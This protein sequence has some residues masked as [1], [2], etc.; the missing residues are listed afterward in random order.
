MTSRLEGKVALVTGAGSGIGR[1]CALMFAREGAQVI[2]CDRDQAGTTETLS[3]AS[4]DKLTIDMRSPV[5]LLD[6]GEVSRLITDVARKYT[7]IDILLT[8]AGR[9]E[10]AP[11]PD[12]TM[13]QWRTTM[14]GELDIVFL[15]VRAAWP[16]MVK[17]GGGSIINFASAAA[18]GGVKG[19]P[20]LAHAAGKGGVL[21]MT[22][23]LAVEGAPHRIRANTIAPGPIATAALERAMNK[24]PDFA[25][26][27]RSKVLLDRLG[28]P[29]DIAYAAVFLASNESNWVTG[30][31]FSVDGGMTAW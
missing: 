9:A 7:R 15:P 26:A 3:M 10:F 25:A 22:R 23:Q 27:V 17:N 14:V 8:A 18:W 20:Q 11:V 29:E 19:L 24:A 4:A 16:F 30:A 5:N 12:I 6:E 2:G 28:K 1:A 31:D 13:D 21:A